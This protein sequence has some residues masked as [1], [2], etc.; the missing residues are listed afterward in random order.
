MTHHDDTDH[1]PYAPP[2]D[3]DAERAVLGSAML[4]ATALDELLD[5]VTAGDFYRPQHETIWHAITALAATGEPVDAL[6]VADQLTTTGTLREAGGGAHLHELIAAVPTAA[7]ASWYAD[8]IRDRATRR[9]L[10]DAG[11]R[12]TDLAHTEPAAGTLPD[13]LAGAHDA[14]AAVTDTTTTDQPLTGYEATSAALEALDAPVGLATPWGPLTRCIAGWKP[15]ALY[16]CGARPSVGKSV[17]A[18]NVLLDAARRGTHTVMFS[19]EMTR[20]D[21]MHRLFSAVGTVPMDHIQH[22]TLST[23]DH[24]GIAEAV[25]HLSELP[26]TIDDRA[27]ISLATIR[28]TLR[29]LHRERPVGL[30]IIDYLQLIAPP[31]G[32]PRNDRR[33]QVDAIS[34][35]LQALAKDLHIPVLALT[36]LNR[37]TE[38]GK[39]AHP[40]LSNLREAGGQEQ[41][42]DVVLLLHRDTQNDPGTLKVIVAK[43]RHGP[44]TQFELDFHGRYARAETRPWSPTSALGEPA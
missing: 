3:L 41:D 6:T 27:A 39:D 43:N 5:T 24:Q 9:R 12:I 18:T 17:I 10:R 44:L 36:Q 32:A 29:R 38:T 23:D 4:S 25:H 13:V 37:A 22:R 1:D 34:R 40:T 15:G 31:S 35:G 20:D 30:V 11:M 7:N 19:L 42:A 16:I 28:S 8:I 2:Q 14:L 21:T 26:L 33:V